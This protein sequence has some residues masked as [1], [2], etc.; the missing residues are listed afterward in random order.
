M[1]ENET[2]K[3]QQQAWLYRITMTKGHINKSLPFFTIRP[4]FFFSALPSHECGFMFISNVNLDLKLLPVCK[5]LLQFLLYNL[6]YCKSSNDQPDDLSSLVKIVQ[7][8][9]CVC[10]YFKKDIWL[11]QIEPL[12]NLTPVSMQVVFKLDIRKTWLAFWGGSL[13]FMQIYGYEWKG[14]TYWVRRLHKSRQF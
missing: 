5:S 4:S 1:L 8:W 9:L 7:Q 12:V 14:D 13:T 10:F 6:K 11:T 2:F 3:K